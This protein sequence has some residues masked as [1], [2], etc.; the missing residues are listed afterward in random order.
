MRFSTLAGGN[1]IPILVWTLILPFT[2][3]GSYFASLGLFTHMHALIRT[4]MKARR[5]PCKSL[6]LAL[7]TGLSSPVLCLANS[8]HHVLPS[9]PTL[10]PQLR[11]TPP[12]GLLPALQPGN[13][14]RPCAREIRGLPLLD[15]PLP[16]YLM[17]SSWKLL[18]YISSW[19]FSCCS[20]TWGGKHF[21]NVLFIWGSPEADSG[22]LLILLSSVF[23]NLPTCYNYL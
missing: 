2:P 8:S 10:S 20:I 21:Y 1:T 6:E 3:L 17:A 18:F 11:A 13:I 9:L 15:S 7:C 12:G 22:I 23:V 16:R 4:H 19:V 5:D 14:S